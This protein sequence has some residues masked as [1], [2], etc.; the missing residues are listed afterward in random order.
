[1]K[2]L[3]LVLLALSAASSA[4]AQ[5][6]SFRPFL[7]FAEQKFVATQ[8]FEATFGQATQSFWGGGLNITSDDRYYLELSASRF[9]KTGTRAFL[10]DGTAFDLHIA[11]RVTITPLEIAAGYRFHRWDKV[12]PTLGGGVGVYK[13]KQ[14]SDFSSDAENVDTQHA[15]L[16]VEGG[17]E[18]RLHRWLGVAGDVHYTYVPGI[19]GD[20][21]FSKDVGEKDLGGLSARV[22]LIVGK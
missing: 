8:T 20:A 18:V 7:M 11:Q 22:K 6:L 14:A 21:G 15:G 16:I 4:S 2:R 5:E 12:L 19:L 3:A 13:Y 17:V 9:D 10:F 1:M